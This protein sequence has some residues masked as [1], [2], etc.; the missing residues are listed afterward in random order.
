MDGLDV[1][2]TRAQLPAELQGG[3]G[4]ANVMD[5][6]PIVSVSQNG[7]E[8]DGGHRDEPG[9]PSRQRRGPPAPPLPPALGQAAVGNLAKR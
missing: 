7:H 1:L 6:L 2:T 9:H 8:D 4:L 5:A 3:F